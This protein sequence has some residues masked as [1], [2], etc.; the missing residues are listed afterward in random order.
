[1][2]NVPRLSFFY[3]IS[4]YM[5]P[6]DHN[7]PHFHVVYAEFS[8]QILVSSGELMNGRLPR[9]AE[10]LVNEWWAVHRREIFRAWMLMQ[11]GNTVEAI[12]PLR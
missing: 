7:P 8:A 6:G 1:M 2:S 12:E 3:G 5:Y 9:R 11:N 4:I 10:R